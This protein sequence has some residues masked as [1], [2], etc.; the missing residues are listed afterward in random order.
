MCTDANPQWLSMEQC[1]EFARW[2]QS[3]V[4]SNKQSTRYK[5]LKAD[6]FLDRMPCCDS[7]ALSDGARCCRLKGYFD[8]CPTL[9]ETRSDVDRV[10]HLDST[11]RA[12]LLP[13]VTPLPDP[14]ER[15]KLQ[16]T[17]LFLV[18]VQICGLV[19]FVMLLM[20]MY[21]RDRRIQR[22]HALTMLKAMKTL[23]EAEH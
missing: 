8:F 23:R 17:D 16:Q 13:L 2:T 19:I 3:E 18:I 14:P 6:D 11:G 21:F 15:D 4:D 5:P 9:S 10:C 20:V 12:A 1:D 7:K 22:K